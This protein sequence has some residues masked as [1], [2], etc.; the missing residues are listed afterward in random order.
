MIPMRCAPLAVCLIAACSGGGEPDNA[1]QTSVSASA[2]PVT[3]AA[4]TSSRLKATVSDLT[5][6]ISGLSTRMSDLGLVVDLPADTLFEFDKATL[7]PTSAAELRKAAELIRNSPPGAITV[8]G[9]SDAK[10][11]AGYNRSL[12]QARAEAVRAWFGQQVGVRQRQFTVV[13]RGEDAPIAPNLS[14]DGKD[15]PIGRAKNRRVEVIVPAK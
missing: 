1:V 12:S 6:D 15:D 2:P 11:D 3:T 7:T 9:H 10:G 14:V 5:A 8:I 4:P 13:G